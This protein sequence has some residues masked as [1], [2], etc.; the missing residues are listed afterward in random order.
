MLD[1][2]DDDDI[3]SGVGGEFNLRLVCTPH[4][5]RIFRFLARGVATL[6]EGSLFCSLLALLLLVA[7]LLSLSSCRCRCCLMH[8]HHWLLIDNGGNLVRGSG[9]VIVVVAVVL[10]EHI[11]APSR[12]I[13]F[14]L[15]RGAAHHT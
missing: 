15:L 1:N 2:D 5:R 3:G 7:S 11:G 8:L 10:R 13:S 9:S 6:A 14:R 4:G 12:I